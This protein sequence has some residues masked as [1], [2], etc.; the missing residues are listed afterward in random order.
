[1]AATQTGSTT[2]WLRIYDLDPS[3]DIVSTFTTSPASGGPPNLRELKALR[4]SKDGTKLYTVS[5][6]SKSLFAF[7]NSGSGWALRSTVA[8]TDVGSSSQN[9]KSLEVTP[10]GSIV[11]SSGETSKLFV[12]KDDGSGNLSLDHT[13][14]PNTSGY[15]L[16]AP[17]AF[18]TSSYYDGFYVLNDGKEVLLYT[19]SEPSKAYTLRMG[20]PLESSVANADS[21]SVL[22]LKNGYCTEI[23]CV[24]GGTDV[25]LYTIDTN[26]GTVAD[27]DS[28]HPDVPNLSGLANADTVCCDG[29]SFLI[30]GGSSGIVSVLGIKR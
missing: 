11:I 6:Q 14:V 13:I 1:V 19:R 24:V 12:F 15:I 26:S 16:K 5:G 20:I 30:G 9:V 28:I 8:L 18:A 22:D 3:G 17:S 29:K 2:G 23:V 4:F 10:S 27:S 21:L 7:V 25:G